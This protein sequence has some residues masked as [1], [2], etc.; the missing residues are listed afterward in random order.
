[1]FSKTFK[2]WLSQNPDINVIKW[3]NFLLTTFDDVDTF[4]ESLTSCLNAW[5]S[6]ISP[7]E[8]AEFRKDE[9][10]A[11]IVVVDHCGTVTIIHH[12]YFHPS[13]RIFGYTTNQ[14]AD[15][16]IKVIFDKDVTKP[17][18]QAFDIKWKQLP[19]ET[20]KQEDPS[21]MDKDTPTKS[22]NMEPLLYDTDDTTNTKSRG[23]SSTA[24]RAS[25]TKDKP[26]AKQ[27]S[28]Q[29]IFNCLGKKDSLDIANIIINSWVIVPPAILSK[30]LPLKQQFSFQSV[31][32]AL[33]EFDFEV[34]T[35]ANNFHK[36]HQISALTCTYHECAEYNLQYR[37]FINQVRD[38]EIIQAV[39][40][41]TFKTSILLN[42]C[43]TCCP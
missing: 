40:N 42:V 33:D 18:S 5:Y 1:M 7:V 37:T 23:T 14:M 4:T 9:P 10:D 35:N 3:S 27:H 17:I 30:L 41:N 20:E 15:N 8:L 34:L 12:L 39:I 21:N 11:G 2:I 22:N 26:D 6:I 13:N 31:Q 24:K 25:K 32:D 29:K 43:C 38:T 16:P 19:M 36:A 28:K